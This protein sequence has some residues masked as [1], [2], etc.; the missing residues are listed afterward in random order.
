MNALF[1]DLRV[2]DYRYPGYGV[3]SSFVS[4]ACLKRG[5]PQAVDRISKRSIISHDTAARPRRPSSLLDFVIN[6]GM[7]R[8]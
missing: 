2:P 1:K 6:P 5:T 3:A 7:S 4:N 8:V